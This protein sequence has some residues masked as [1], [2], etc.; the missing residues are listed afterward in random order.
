MGAC[1]TALLCSTGSGSRGGHFPLP[2]P[3]GILISSLHFFRR[4]VVSVHDAQPSLTLC[5]LQFPP[6]RRL[7]YQNLQ[8]RHDQGG[9]E[10]NKS[11]DCFRE[12]ELVDNSWVS[13][14]ER[15]SLT[16]VVLVVMMINFFDVEF[17]HFCEESTSTR[18]EHC[19]SMPTVAKTRES[20]PHWAGHMGGRKPLGGTLTPTDGERFNKELQHDRRSQN[21]IMVG[22]DRGSAHVLH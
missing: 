20:S 2:S 15:Q 16:L 14:S 12:G 9:A 22:G 21:S 3:R 8:G 11:V 17:V 5:L 10:K 19:V 18:Q 7:R 1:F 6:S 13:A 4:D